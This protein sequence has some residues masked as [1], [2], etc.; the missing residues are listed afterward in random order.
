M[1][2]PA[3]LRD[4]LA[5]DLDRLAEALAASAARW[6]RGHQHEQDD[7]AD[8]QSAGSRWEARDGGASL[9]T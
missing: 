7:P 4:P 6:G 8:E 2:A 9:T 5:A 3:T 1:T